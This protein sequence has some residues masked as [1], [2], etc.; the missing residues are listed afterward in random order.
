MAIG[1]EFRSIF[2]AVEYPVF[3]RAVYQSGFNLLQAKQFMR[4]AGW[5][6]PT[7][8]LPRVSKSR[9]EQAFEAWKRLPDTS[10]RE[11]HALYKLALM[12][13]QHVVG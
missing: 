1:A 2:Q 9:A 8:K 6:D 12:E 3:C 11:F 7:P 5:V 10:K 4:K 13:A